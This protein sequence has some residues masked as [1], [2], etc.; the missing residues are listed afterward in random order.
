MT[1]CRYSHTICNLWD[2]SQTSWLLHTK[3]KTS[4]HVA[5]VGGMHLPKVTKDLP[6]LDEKPLNCS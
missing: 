4:K 2:P 3:L 1:K 6:W 5:Y